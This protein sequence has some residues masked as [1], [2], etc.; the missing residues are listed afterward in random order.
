MEID[1]KDSAQDKVDDYDVDDVEIAK[2]RCVS[3]ENIDK[4][5]MEASVIISVTQKYRS[6]MNVLTMKQQ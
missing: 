4:A 6:H 5:N 3:V 2:C 1:P